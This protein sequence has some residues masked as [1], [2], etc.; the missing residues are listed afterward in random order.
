MGKEPRPHRS[1]PTEIGFHGA[2]ADLVE[3]VGG[4]LLIELT[5][6]AMV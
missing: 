4:D 6:E 5:T 3:G 1:Q 2:L